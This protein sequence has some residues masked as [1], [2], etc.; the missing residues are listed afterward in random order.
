MAIGLPFWISVKELPLKN[1]IIKNKY[2]HVDYYQN[3]S[4]YYSINTVLNKD[5]QYY[6]YNT[7]SYIYYVALNL[8]FE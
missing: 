1:V 4:E 5:V 3:D 7:Y 6:V 8:Y 2:D